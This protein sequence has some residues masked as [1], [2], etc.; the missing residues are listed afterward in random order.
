M[1][2]VTN[3]Y[4]DGYLIVDTSYL[5]HTIACRAMK[6]YSQHYDLPEDEEE[7]W[8]INFSEDEDFRAIFDRNFIS[9]INKFLKKFRLHKNNIVFALDCKKIDIWR[10]SFYEGYKLGR[11]NASHEKKGFNRGPLFGY[12]KE[13]VLPNLI[14]KGFG[15]IIKHPVAEGD[16]VIAV[17]HRYLRE[18]YPESTIAIMTC[19][20]DFLQLA[21]DYTEIYNIQDKNLKEKS[22]GSPALDLLMKILVG[23]GADEIPKCFQKTK[24]DKYLSRGFGNKAAMTL[25]KDPELLK[26]KFNEYPEAKEQ[27]KLN[28]TLVCFKA[29]PELIVEDITKN[30]KELVNSYS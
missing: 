20:H 30:L 26:E 29:I 11:I 14:E 1:G 3:F 12:V 13:T 22:L 10:R 24:G 7:L 2:L 4:E 28:Y 5:T 8:K 18:T 25:I 23:D 16:D 19:D 21:D 9:T 17:S 6:I 27:Y 15:G